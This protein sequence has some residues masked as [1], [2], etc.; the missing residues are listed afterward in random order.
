MPLHFGVVMYHR[1]HGAIFLQRSESLFGARFYVGDDLRL[2][3]KMLEQMLECVL[4]E[5]A[6]LKSQLTSLQAKM[7]QM[8]N[9]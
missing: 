8:G 1:F 3:N 9:K 2:R 7:E 4:A 6:E 5:N